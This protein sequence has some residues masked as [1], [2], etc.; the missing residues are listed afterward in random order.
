MAAVKQSFKSCWASG[1]SYRWAVEGLRK[2]AGAR[3]CQSACSSQFGP[4]VMKRTISKLGSVDL[5]LKPLC[6]RTSKRAS[7]RARVAG[8]PA[9]LIA[10]A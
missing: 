6:T 3:G 5:W 8:F 7:G 1:S 2:S 9:K 4:A 10:I